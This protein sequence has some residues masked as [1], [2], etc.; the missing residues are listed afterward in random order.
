MKCMNSL[1]A[2]KAMA[3][4]LTCFQFYLF[5]TSEPN[6]VLLFF[7]KSAKVMARLCKNKANK[8]RRVRQR[9]RDNEKA[10]V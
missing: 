6:A 5:C 8:Q 2:V 9:E 1:L 4:V 7:Q 3:A 10:G